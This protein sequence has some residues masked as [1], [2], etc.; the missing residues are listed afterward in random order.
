MTMYTFCINGLC[1][2]VEA[3]SEEDAMK[4]ARIK[5]DDAYNLIEADSFDDRCFLPAIRNKIMFAS[6]RSFR[7]I[8]P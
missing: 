5:E 6:E 8:E 3:D 1:K 2:T 7:Y 4:E